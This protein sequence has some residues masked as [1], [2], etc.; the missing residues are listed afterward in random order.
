MS[1]AP[2]E[3]LGQQLRSRRVRMGLSLED[4]AGLAEISKGYLS[5]IENG[6]VGPPSEKKLRTLERVL[7]LA[8]GELIDPVR[9]AKAVKPQP[10][11]RFLD[12]RRRWPGIS[13]KECI[14]ASVCDESM[15]P[16]YRKGDVVVFSSAAAPLDGDDCLARLS[17]G[18]TLFV[19]AFY[20]TFPDGERAVRL[21][22]R[23]QN[24]SAMILPR[25]KV[26]RLS[27]AVF[28]YHRIEN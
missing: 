14:A 27:K 8:R 25:D 3:F 16:Q 26:K 19:Q 12:G 9:R 7:Q 18:Q 22:P 21:Q 24:Y 5:L 1:A 15:W 2:D 13:R 28:R 23:N 17:N 4:L 10:P 11:I 20:Q 6:R